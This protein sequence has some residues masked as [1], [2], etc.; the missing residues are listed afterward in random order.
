MVI[1]FP[2]QDRCPGLRDRLCLSLLLLDMDMDIGS[3]TEENMHVL[4]QKYVSFIQLPHQSPIAQPLSPRT[5]ADALCFMNHFSSCPLF[6]ESLQLMPFV[7][8]YS[9]NKKPLFFIQPVQFLISYFFQFSSQPGFLKIK[10]VSYLIPVYIF[11]AS[12]EN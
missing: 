6:H 5:E 12:L 11:L 8:G 1:L 3:I 10:A 9:T 7:Q 4:Q 2:K